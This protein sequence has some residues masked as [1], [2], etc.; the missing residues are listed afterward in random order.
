METLNVTLIEPR[1]KHATIFN[2][3]DALQ[4]GEAFIIFN[5][6]DP[7]PL[8]YQL[9]GER[10]N[11]FTWDYLEEGPE[12]WQVKI[13]KRGS[14]AN[15]ETVGEIALKDFRKAGAFKKL[16]I[17][18]C[19]GG[20]KTLK[21]AIRAAG[22]TEEQLEDALEKS[23]QAPVQ[24]RAPDFAAWSPG[25]MAD[26]I[27]NQHHHYVR[28]NGPLIEGLADKV[29]NRHGQQHPE[30]I[31]LAYGVKILMNEL[32][33]HLTKEEKVVFPAIRQLE[34]LRTAGGSK[35][36]VDAAPL[37][38]VM[39]TEHEA[40]SAEL[41]NFRKLTKD[42]ALPADA[43]NSYTYLFEKLGEFEDDLF[44]HIHLENNVLFPK[45]LK[46]QEKLSS[47]DV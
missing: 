42:Y 29:A 1:L 40:A 21:E 25:F 46:I 11:T 45:A 5:D 18:F 8:Y 15:E 27:V 24:G 41:R 43:C 38:Q 33:S 4:A 23:G 3:F 13:A 37:I 20:K 22:I 26:Y 44:T 7:R 2:R 31:E 39:E 10:G 35:D 12:Y 30:L 14:A 47:S 32:Y 34:A 36:R 17:D 28:E 9:L 6:H 16:G 19:C